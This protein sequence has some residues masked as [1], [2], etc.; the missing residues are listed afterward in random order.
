MIPGQP[1]NSS[2]KWLVVGMLW[3]VCFFNYADRQAIFAVF[4]L[5]KRE[6][7]LTDLQLGVVGAAFMWVYAVFGPLAGWLC[8]RLPRKS[9]VLGGLIAWSLVTML[10]AVCHTYGQLA[11]AVPLADW[12]RLSISQLRCLSSG[13]ITE[14]VPALAP[15]LFISQASMWAR[16]QAALFP[17]LWANSMAGDGASFSLDSADSYLA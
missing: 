2:Y 17:V 7:V 16:L 14:Q 6:L 4:P 3:F 1:P 5:I 12:E 13:T 9:L 15:C 11:C 10:T 8:D